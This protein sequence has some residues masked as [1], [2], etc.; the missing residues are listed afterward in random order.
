LHCGYS[1]CAKDVQL[2]FSAEPAGD[3]ILH[4]YLPNI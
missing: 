3:F 1:L 4:Q 2:L